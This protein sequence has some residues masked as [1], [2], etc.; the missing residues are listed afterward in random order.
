MC[1]HLGGGQQATEASTGSL[2]RNGYR[3]DIPHPPGSSGPTAV[4]GRVAHRAF[5]SGTEAGDA[6]SPGC[7][8]NIRELADR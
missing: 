8:I 2:R 4:E 7:C 6:V 1:E 5:L 3:K